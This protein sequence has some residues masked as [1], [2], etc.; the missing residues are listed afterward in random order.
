[1]SWLQNLGMYSSGLFISVV[2]GVFR[3]LAPLRAMLKDKDGDGGEHETGTAEQGEG[4]TEA[5]LPDQ[6]R[7]SQRQE[8]AHQTPRDDQGGHGGRGVEFRRVDDVRRHG[9]EAEHGRVADQR[10]VDQQ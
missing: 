10:E 3:G 5:E 6:R 8:R 4:I 2:S 9:Q 1:M 7:G